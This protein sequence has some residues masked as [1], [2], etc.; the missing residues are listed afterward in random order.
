MTTRPNDV[1][2]VSIYVVFTAAGGFQTK[3]QLSRS[4]CF[5]VLKT[6]GLVFTK[7]DFESDYTV[8]ITRC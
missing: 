6:P 1:A 5:H 3:T 2:I 7:A 4:L 8:D